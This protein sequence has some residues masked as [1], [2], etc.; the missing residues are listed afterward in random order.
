[1]TCSKGSVNL[2]LRKNDE[3][4]MIRSSTK[5]NNV[6]NESMLTTLEFDQK[7]G[8]LFDKELANPP[9]ILRCVNMNAMGNDLSENLRVDF[10]PTDHQT[11]D[12]SIIT[13][14]KSSDPILELL[15]S[16]VDKALGFNDDHSRAFIQT[17]LLREIA[18]EFAPGEQ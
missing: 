2:D 7:Y 13:F 15:T 17:L 18:E 16:Q 1:M 3:G 10:F 11:G 5:K 12:Y 6:C 14:R 8:D 4:N 9:G